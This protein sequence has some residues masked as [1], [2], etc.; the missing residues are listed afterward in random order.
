MKKPETFPKTGKA[1]DKAGP[2]DLAFERIVDVPR[3]KIWAAWTQPELLKQ[4][5][6]PLPWQTVDA[7]V[8]LRP[9]GRF[10]T[11]MRSPEG[12]EFPDTG[13]YLEVIPFERLVWTN[14]LAPGFRPASP[15]SVHLAFTGII[16]L[17]P[18]GAGTRYQVKVLH[19]ESESRDRHSAMGFAVG[20]GKA[21]DQMVAMIKAM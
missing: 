11:L 3:E 21:L 4:W 2:L 20:W 7:A 15:G 6:T 9:G 19:A 16:A 12:Q 17:A 8:D 14:V 18:H 1:Q 5:F 10:H 13:C